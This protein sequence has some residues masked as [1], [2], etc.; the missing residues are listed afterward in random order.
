MCLSSQSSGEGRVDDYE[1]LYDI[2]PSLEFG[3]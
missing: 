3:P 2:R 1:P